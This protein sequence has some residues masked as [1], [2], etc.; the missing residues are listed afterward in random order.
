MSERSENELQK[1]LALARH[2]QQNDPEKAI[3]EFG[4]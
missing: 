1:Y 4:E 2:Y 3:K